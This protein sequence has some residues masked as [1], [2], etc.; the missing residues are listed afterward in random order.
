MLN[1]VRANVHGKFA[2]NMI[3]L[4]FMNQKFETGGGGE[5]EGYRL[6]AIQRTHL[7]KV[8]RL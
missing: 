2:L 5:A 3:A 1:K 8:N 6:Q 4:N 7:I